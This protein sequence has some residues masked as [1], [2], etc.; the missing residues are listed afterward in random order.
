[1]RGWQS[2][3]LGP[4]LSEPNSLFIIPSQTGDM[5]LEANME[6]RF[7]LFWKIAGALF[8]DA[9]NVWM[10]QPD[11]ALDNF[12]ES[13]AAN[14]GTGV[15]VDMDFIV[16]RIDMGMRLHDPARAA[17]ERWLRPSDWLHRNGYAVHFGVGYP[18]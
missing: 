18:F 2:R 12:F 17:G 16:L 9:G 8:L 4:G 11:A 5:K 1:M 3:A 10:L 13:I 6:Y 14:W 7:G 15:R